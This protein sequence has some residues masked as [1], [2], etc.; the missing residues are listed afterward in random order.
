MIFSEELLAIEF[1]SKFLRMLVLSGRKSKKVKNIGS[2]S[3]SD[4]VIGEGQVID[5]AKLIQCV[6]KLKEDIGVR[7]KLRTS[8]SLSGE[9]VDIISLSLS[10]E[11]DEILEEEIISQAEQA[12]EIDISTVYYDYYLGKKDEENNLYQVTFASC[13]KEIV[14]EYIDVI[15]SSGLNVGVIEAGAFSLLNMLEYNYGRTKKLVVLFNISWDSSYAVFCAR[16]N[17][18]YSKIFSTGLRD[19]IDA[20]TENMKLEDKDAYRLFLEMSLRRRIIS[21]EEKEIIDGIN[22]DIVGQLKDEVES[23]LSQIADESG[24]KELGNVILSGI[25]SR[26]PNIALNL[27]ESLASRVVVSNVFRK[28]NVPPNLSRKVSL[29]GNSYSYAVGLALREFKI[30][31]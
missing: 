1:D 31:Y 24:V 23:C 25:G 22:N 2:L 13:K 7:K 17:Y 26:I 18:V 14:D 27:K 16:G 9:V 4:S 19:Y 8:F 5:K 15:L 20:F 21:S 30:K 3:L 11:A 10:L 28:V 6:T 29:E 12:M